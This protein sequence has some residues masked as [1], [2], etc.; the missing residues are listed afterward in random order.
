M[1]SP[2]KPSQTFGLAGKVCVIIGGSGLI[3]S[4]FSRLCAAEGA[5]VVIVGRDQKK[6]EALAKQ[7]EKK[8]GIAVFERCDVT[9]QASVE[10]LVS[11]V[12]KRFKRVD[13][14]VNSAHFGTGQPG[15]SLLEVEQADFLAYLDR[16]VGG[17]FLVAREFAKKMKIQKSG[18]IVFMSSIYGT[19][20]PRFEIFEG[21]NQTVRAEYA[22]AK[23]ALIQLAR[24]FAKDLGRW[25]VRVNVISPGAV[26]NQQAPSVRV[27]YESQVPLGK[28][29]A[30]PDD[31]SPTLVFLFSEASK[32]ITGQNIIVDGGWT[33]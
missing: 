17:P 10:A 13:G 1:K 24:F 30:R 11:R 16:N 27:A 6:G 3:G 7:I 26:K 31:I 25:G 15:K 2:A 21:T 33:L 4:E 19:V 23:A 5:K 28:R 14:L 22:A 29:M 9:D 32:Y 18:S 20:P 8:G 12:Y